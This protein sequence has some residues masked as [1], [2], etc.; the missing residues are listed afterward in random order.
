LCNILWKGAEQGAGI[1]AAAALERDGL[2]KNC[3]LPM[4]RASSCT[5]LSA[6]LRQGWGEL[7]AFGGR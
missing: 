6:A 1:A 5:K 2:P 4:L 3:V 7:R